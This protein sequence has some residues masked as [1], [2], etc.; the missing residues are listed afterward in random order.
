VRGESVDAPR[1]TQQQ[2]RC[3]VVVVVLEEALGQRVGVEEVEVGAERGGDGGAGVL[4]RPNGL[5]QRGV[6]SCVLAGGLLL[7][8]VEVCCRGGLDV[9]ACVVV[10]SLRY[11]CM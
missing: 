8:G 11:A 9:V 5:V 10:D 3:P 7:R 6:C 2:A 1:D 4:Q